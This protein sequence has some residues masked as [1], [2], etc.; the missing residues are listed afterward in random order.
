MDE[1]TALNLSMNETIAN[2][3]DSSEFQI[4]SQSRRKQ[5]FYELY[6]IQQ[7]IESRILK[8]NQYARKLGDSK[9][10]LDNAK[11]EFAKS[12]TN[13]MNS[14]DAQEK[15]L[16][17]KMKELNQRAK[18]ID[19]DIANFGPQKLAIEQNIRKTESNIVSTEARLITLT[20]TD[21]D[22]LTEDILTPII[23][24]IKATQVLI[25]E[26]NQ[27]AKQVKDVI[28]SHEQTVVKIKKEFSK[29]MKHA[30]KCAEIV[31]NSKTK[32]KEIENNDNIKSETIQT[33][34]QQILIDKDK[35]RDE[36]VKINDRIGQIYVKIN[37]IDLNDTNVD[38]KVLLK[39]EEVNEL[40]NKIDQIKIQQNKLN[41]RKTSKKIQ[42][43]QMK[44]NKKQQT[45][46]Y[47]EL[48]SQLE[49][50]RSTQ[51]VVNEELNKIFA[52]VENQRR[53]L[54]ELEFKSKIDEMDEEGLENY[55]DDMRVKY[56]KKKDEG[57]QLITIL[58]TKIEQKKD[59]ILD[60]SIKY[61][62]AVSNYDDLLNILIIENDIYS[63]VL[64]S[65]REILKIKG[66][67][68]QSK[69]VQLN[70]MTSKLSLLQSNTEN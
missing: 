38:Q 2:L 9:Q 32:F 31:S 14:L 15:S 34:K 13:Q 65:K 62:K 17:N 45:A 54:E 69:R 46:K 7:E 19:T 29:E 47:I 23:D 66:I 48:E 59:E 21:E 26:T 60:L 39:R 41:E 51:K 16:E 6:D 3:M 68:C 58:E 57:N 11:K 37:E 24:D 36:I 70:N 42:S 25:K 30:E 28:S 5:K 50:T 18:D 20:P 64:E 10:E 22:K 63:Q 12:I 53:K 67:L 44:K 43:M 56:E 4:N 49:I 55:L 40:K 52:H 1:S 35:M 8:L 27:H 61:S 33:Q